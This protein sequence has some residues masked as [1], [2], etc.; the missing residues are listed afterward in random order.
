MAIL[1]AGGAGYIGSHTVVA[2][3]EAGKE[4]VVVDTLEYGH[5]KAIFADRF[6]K[7]SILDEVSLKKIFS[8][9]HIEAV[10]HFCAYIEVG[11][12]VSNPIKYYTNNVIG[13]LTLLK[14]MVESDVKN[15]VFSSTAAVYGE[16]EKVPI[17]EDMKKEPKNPY[18]QTKLDFEH[19]LKW[20]ADA[21]G[22]NYAALRYFNACGAH[23]DGKIGEDHSPESHLI[24]LILQVPLGKRESI[25]IFGDDFP[26]RD[27]TCI[28]DYIHVS[29]LASAHVLAAEKLISE[30][31]RYEYNL[32]NGVGFTVKEV[33][34]CAREIT[35]H[36]IPAVVTPRRAGD[37]ASL[38]ASSEKALSELSWKPKYNDLK[39]II[40]SAWNWHKNNPNG[41]NDR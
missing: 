36:A 15:I 35:G 37:P 14:A 22:I 18:G 27:G 30:G 23:K 16:P 21:Y 31:G 34:E 11:E 29:D 6:Y 28:R 38:I 4:V 39:T 3:K 7:A 1:V 32:G 41:F 2:L 20:Y 19:A 33:I 25:K 5:E 24:P 13:A 40:E 26:T 17:T 12:S 10:M 9:N 8:E